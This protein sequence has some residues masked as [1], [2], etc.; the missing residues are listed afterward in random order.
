MKYNFRSTTVFVV[1]LSMMVGMTLMTA[2]SKNT[3]TKKTQE[4]EPTKKTEALPQTEETVEETGDGDMKAPEIKPNEA[5]LIALSQCPISYQKLKVEVANDYSEAKIYD[6]DKLLQT[7]SDPDG[8]LVAAGGEVPVYF[9]DANF[10]GYV[11]IF[12]GPGESRT[13]STLLIWNPADKQFVRVGELGSPALQNFM[14]Y[15]SGK[16]VFD[17]GS[18]SAFA[19]FF[20]CFVWK[21]GGLQKM[22]DLYVVNDPEQFIEYGVEAKYTLR[23]AG[24]KVILSTEKL[25][26]LPEPWAGLLKL[27]TGE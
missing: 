22:N 11:D 20:T 6:G 7:I 4:A 2:C 25:S 24:D 8:G 17:G 5:G 1:A 9:M 12:I 10:D 14:L 15:P 26:D 19:D 27:Y 18:E 3:E 23:N 13:Y 16:M 21:D